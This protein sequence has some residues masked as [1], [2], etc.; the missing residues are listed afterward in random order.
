M[1]EGCLRVETFVIVKGPRKIFNE[2]FK[3]AES[4]INRLSLVICRSNLALS[5]SA[6]HVDTL[7]PKWN[8]GCCC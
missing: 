2:L 7:Q 8:E 6:Y 1:Y 5:S 4:K 3:I